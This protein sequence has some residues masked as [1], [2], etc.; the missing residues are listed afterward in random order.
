VLGPPPKVTWLRIANAPT[1]DVM[2]LLRT[3][4]AD[5]QAFLADPT[6]AILELP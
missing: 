4:A 5:V 1:R 3:R 6:Q 2:A